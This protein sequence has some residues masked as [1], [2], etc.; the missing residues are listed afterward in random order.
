TNSRSF[1]SDNN[2]GAHP[3]ILEALARANAGHCVS[4][5]ADPWTEEARGH[6]RRLF[7]EEA[8]AFFVFNGTGANVCALG[9]LCRPWHAVVCADTAH[10]NVDECGAPE[11]CGGY[12]LLPVPAS[13]GKITPEAIATR[14]HGFGFQHHSQPRVVS[15]TQSTELGAVYTAREIRAIA[16]QAHAHGLL[17]HLDGAR[18]AN[19]AESLDCT[20]RALTTD[21]GVDALSFGGAK[22]GLMLGEAVVFLRPGLADE[23]KY[24]RK[25]NTQLPSKMRFIA[26]Q[27]TELLKDG[28]WLD[29]ARQANAMARLLA[30]RV[31]GLPGVAVAGRVDTNAVFA[32]LPRRAAEQLKERYFFYTWDEA[33]DGEAPLYR[34]MTSFDTTRKDVE[35]FA[36]ALEQALAA[37]R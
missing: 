5:G 26:A 7:G 27:F 30:D 12:K 2:S 29:N 25:Q 31:A 3:R 20:L 21:C 28:L 24:L 16:E 23:F 14:L 15:I 11:H 10:I 36:Q 18:L 37:A 32:R 9:T 13:Q 19:A 1:A 4:Y 17:L 35:E 34:W 33:G 22:N 8:E 6:F